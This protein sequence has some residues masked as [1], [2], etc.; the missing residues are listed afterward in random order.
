MK[1]QEHRA[2]IIKQ[3]DIIKQ[4]DAEVAQ[5]RAA[6]DAQAPTKELLLVSVVS[7]V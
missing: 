4:R 1:L 3:E 6:F 7:T 2:D 5:K